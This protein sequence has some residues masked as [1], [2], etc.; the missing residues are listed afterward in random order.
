MK[1]RFGS[2]HKLQHDTQSEHADSELILLY[3]KIELHFRHFITSVGSRPVFAQNVESILLTKFYV[4][5]RHI[6]VMLN[7]NHLF[8][9]FF[10]QIL[11]M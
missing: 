6:P 8:V 5:I 2:Q 9:F 7:S 11:I 1:T 4:G 10:K 3:K